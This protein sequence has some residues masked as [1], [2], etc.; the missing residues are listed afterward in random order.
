MAAFGYV[1]VS[2]DRQAE[3]GESLGAQERTI[4]G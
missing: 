2:T 1:R 4:Q 3:E